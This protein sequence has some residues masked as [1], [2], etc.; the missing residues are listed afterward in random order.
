[1]KRRREIVKE[2]A[3]YEDLRRDAER[4][5]PELPRHRDSREALGR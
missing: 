2:L 4:C 1:M 3:D 5:A